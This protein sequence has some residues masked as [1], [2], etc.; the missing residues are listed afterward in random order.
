MT[1]TTRAGVALIVLVHA[2]TGC[3]DAG[4]ALPTAPTPIARAE[5][6][7][8]QGGIVMRGTVSDTAFRELPGAR[9]EI[10]NGPHAGASATVDGSGEFSFT[11]AFDDTTQFRATSEG[12]LASVRTLQPFCERCNPNW[13]I[14]FTLDVPDSPVTVAG[15]YALTVTAG[16]CSMLPSDA[17]SRTFIATVPQ[18]MIPAPVPGGVVVVAISGA[19]VL[20]GWDA[21]GVGVA[22]DYLAFWLETLV[23][24]VAPNRYLAFSGQAAGRVDPSDLATIVLPFAG[25]IDDCT[26]P[27][28]A[29]TFMDCYRTP[30]ATRRTC[31]AT[32]HQF[33]LTRR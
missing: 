1:N 14:N 9:V 29:G 8:S 24:Q 17:R 25:T 21:I 31:T 4:Q 15:T 7:S 28:E 13:W 2:L 6:L 11:G 32:D 19:T 33:V 5:A 3:D 18:E 16:R 23:E 12:H 30:Q 26:T 10:L 22:G 20:P 27:S